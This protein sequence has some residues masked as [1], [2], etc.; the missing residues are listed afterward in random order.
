MR[1]FALPACGGRGS[2]NEVLHSLEAA[3]GNTRVLAVQLDKKEVVIDTIR[4][5]YGDP[6]THNGDLVER[7]GRVTFKLG[8]TS[9][10]S[11]V[12]RTGRQVQSSV[13]KS[14]CQP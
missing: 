5:A 4:W 13:L 9:W 14:L 12:I 10:P 8:R 2:A 3:A 1:R 11:G 7:L 6:R